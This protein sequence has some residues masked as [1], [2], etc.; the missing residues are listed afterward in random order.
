MKYILGY[1]RIILCFNFLLYMF[2]IILK[3]KLFL[4]YWGWK[5]AL[6]HKCRDI[7][8]RCG[9]IADEHEIFWGRFVK[10]LTDSSKCASNEEIFLQLCFLLWL[11]SVILNTV[12]VYRP[13]KTGQCNVITTLYC[14]AFVSVRLL[15][16]LV[17]TLIC[18]NKASKDILNTFMYSLVLLLLT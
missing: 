2:N 9:S 12:Q 16:S 4:Y 3:I 14:L 7:G 8:G 11:N 6:H 15:F 5:K 18:Y 17:M 13:V 10:T 1:C